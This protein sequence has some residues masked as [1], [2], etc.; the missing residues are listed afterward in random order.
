M[1]TSLM[2]APFGKALMYCTMLSML[3]S[4]PSMAAPAYPGAGNTPNG[5]VLNGSVASQPVAIPVA[6]DDNSNGLFDIF[7]SNETPAVQADTA[8][9][10]T[11]TQADMGEPDS[12]PALYH[13]RIELEVDN[14]PAL[15]ATRTEIDT[16]DTNSITPAVDKVAIDPQAAPAAISTAHMGEPDNSPAL[17]EARTELPPQKDANKISNVLNSFMKPVDASASDNTQAAD[18]NGPKPVAAYESPGI[19]VNTAR[20]TQAQYQPDLDTKEITLAALVPASGETAQDSGPLIQLPAANDTKPAPVAVPVAT[21]QIKTK[22]SPQVAVE[23][24]EPRRELSPASKAMLRKIPANIDSPPQKSNSPIAIDHAKNSKSSAVASVKHEEMG[25][26]IEVKEPTL[27]LTYELEKAYNATIAG[28]TS[29]AMDIYK[30]ILTNDPKNK[31]ALFGL[32]TLYHRAGQIDAARKLYS[33]LLSIDPSN[34]DALNNF[35]VLMAD[36]APEAALEQLAQLEKRDPKFSP[37]PA[38]MAI[39][40]QKM[41]NMDMAS[42]KMFRAVDLSPENLIYRYNLAIMLDKQQ[43][44]DEAGKLY[45]QIVQAYQRGQDIPGNI[46][47]IQQR[48]IFI[49]SNKH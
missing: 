48:L 9:A 4:T 3:A 47:Q 27:D 11:E 41:G 18:A 31:G 40:Y 10:T 32:G 38:Q 26:K 33:Q 2:Q 20:H 1:R 43:K 8:P 42:E 30:S 44:Y 22:P 21:P 16:A 37:I 29:I 14:S 34:R 15:F 23:A 19:V 24:S 6:K 39:I 25:I 49:S 5:T 45:H 7:G 12:S 35:L 46:T 13:A 28:Q 36:E 17:Y